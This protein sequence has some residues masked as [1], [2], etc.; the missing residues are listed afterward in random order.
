VL[1]CVLWIIC[2]QSTSEFH[3]LCHI[4][5]SYF[6]F[7]CR[8]VSLT[9]NHLWTLFFSQLDNRLALIPSTRQYLV[10]ICVALP[11]PLYKPMPMLKIL[12]WWWKLKI[13]D[14]SISSSHKFSYKDHF[15][16]KKQRPEIE[17]M[18]LLAAYVLCQLL[19][20]ILNSIIFQGLQLAIETWDFHQFS[21]VDSTYRI[22][23]FEYWKLCCADM[24]Y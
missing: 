12:R 17:F 22:S 23:R 15:I 4:I 21:H 11:L 10:V 13:N 18:V 8:L 9:L 6:S 20:R 7:K 1:T 14:F 2:A 19:C 3:V 16:K 24:M 5:W